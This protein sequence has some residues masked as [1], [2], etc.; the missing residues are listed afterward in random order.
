MTTLYVHPLFWKRGVPE[1][2]DHFPVV[3]PSKF[4]EK[5]VS[6][7]PALAKMAVVAA[8]RREGR[9]FMRLDVRG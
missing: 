6:A 4:S 5:I 9:R 8:R 7:K 1:D 2:E 3:L